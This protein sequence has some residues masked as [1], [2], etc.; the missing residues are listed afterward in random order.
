MRLRID[1]DHDPIVSRRTYA[2]I[3][4][5]YFCS[6]HPQRSSRH[7]LS[8]SVFSIELADT[9]CDVVSARDFSYGCGKSATLS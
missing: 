9:S 1:I 4:R 7:L 6:R 2:R 5:I 3:H 8:D